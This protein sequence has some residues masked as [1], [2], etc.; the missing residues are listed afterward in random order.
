M[1]IKNLYFH[2]GKTLILKNINLTFEEGKIYGLIGVNG[3]GKTTLLSILSGIFKKYKGEINGI[4]KAGLL[5]QGTTLYEEA[6]GLENLKLFCKE[7]QL[8]FD[9]I[10]YVLEL[11][12]IDEENRNKKVKNCSQG[13]KQRLG[14]ARSFLTDSNM[15]VLDEPFTAVDLP[16]IQIL[17]KAIKN[18]VAQNNKTIIIS[19]HQLRE[20]EELINVGIIIDKGEI[21]NIFDFDERKANTTNSTLF[22]TTLETEK[23][24]SIFENIDLKLEDFSEGLKINF[25]ENYPIWKILQF[26][27]QNNLTWIRI[28]TREPLETIFHN[29]LSSLSKLAE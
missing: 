28:E 6:T 20:I 29:Q 23:W 10:N 7:R 3:A 26:A 11:V 14:I 12:G 27:T 18:Y 9:R 19:S 13:F 16:T 5:I 8:D 4:E 17:K 2:Y 22:I 25:T 15:V 1:T 24:I 21:K